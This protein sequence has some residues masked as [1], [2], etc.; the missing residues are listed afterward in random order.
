MTEKL[1][2]ALADDIAKILKEELISASVS[3]KESNNNEVSKRSL[4][5]EPHKERTADEKTDSK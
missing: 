5:G 4:G 2:K 3:F 1:E